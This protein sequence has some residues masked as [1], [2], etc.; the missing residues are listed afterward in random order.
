MNGMEEIDN[1]KLIANGLCH[2]QC[3]MLSSAPSLFR[4]A[5]EAPLVLY[6]SMIEALRG[7]SNNVVLERAGI[8]LYF[9]KLGTKPWKKIERAENT[10][11][12]AWRFSE[13]ADVVV[14]EVGLFGKRRKQRE[15][16]LIG[17]YDALAMVQVECFMSHF[18][19]AKPALISDAEMEALSFLHG[20]VRNIYEH[21][22]PRS[23][24]ATKDELIT[25]SRTALKVAEFI[26]M[27]SGN[28][29]FHSPECAETALLIEGF[30]KCLEQMRQDIISHKT[31]LQPSASANL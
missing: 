8:R 10:R 28:V 27:E 4:I 29:F 31:H 7:T 5:R 17:F 18:V 6:R 1:Q 16:F 20:Q 14:P 22:V 9:Y 3:E 23:Y 30:M 13:P 11:G 25:A 24:S 15:D 21:F 12:R 19:N 2:I 26:L